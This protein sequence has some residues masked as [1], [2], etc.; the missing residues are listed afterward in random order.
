MTS[1]LMSVGRRRRGSSLASA[2]LHRPEKVA[3]YVFI[4]PTVVLFALFVGY[5][6]LRTI[7][8]SFTSWS[9][10]GAA[11][12][13]GLTNYTRVF[14]D[15][16]ARQSFVHTL[17]FAGVTTILQTV[18][19]LIVAVLVNAT[20]RRYGVLV[21]T[22]LFI[23]GIISFVVSGVIWRLVLDP[24]VGLLNRLLDSLGL[25]SLVHTWLG[26][27]STALPAIILVSLWQSLGLNMLIF[28]AGLQG[29][30]P[31]LY[32]AAEV[33]GASGVQRFRYVTIPG[34]RLV[35]G[36]VVSLN[37]INGFKVFDLVYVMTEGGPNHGSE[38]L[39]TQLYGLAFG[40]T[41]GSI[42][43]FGYASTLS[44]IVLVLCTAAVA[45]QIAIT[46]RTAS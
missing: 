21:R 40:S 3:G 26:E 39:G 38:V 20:W 35:T 8:I 33:D 23:P 27:S 37:L 9:G 10:F 42:P 18:L 34:M 36:L 30:D 22:L 6:I 46:R 4:V 25:S 43:Q 12:W 17:L 31:T 44:V 15:A 1:L 41:A 45:I 29:I 13:T 5:P 16:V 28:F 7:Y 11:R 19:P 32:E 2:R 24:N 14:H